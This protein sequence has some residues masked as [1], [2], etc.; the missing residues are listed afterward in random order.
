MMS[1]Y[2]IELH[3]A[4][5]TGYCADDISGEVVFFEDL[6]EARMFAKDSLTEEYVLARIV[7]AKNK[8]VVDFFKA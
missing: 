1:E 2:Y 5:G 4:Q 8:R 6:D 7:D 3:D